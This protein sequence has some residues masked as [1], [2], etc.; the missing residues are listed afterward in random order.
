MLLKKASVECAN[1]ENK[2]TIMAFVSSLAV[3][4]PLQRRAPVTSPRRAHAARRGTARMLVVEA[5]G[6]KDMDLILETAKDALVV[7]RIVF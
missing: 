7:V 4:S 6:P 5:K 2:G 1:G 3:L